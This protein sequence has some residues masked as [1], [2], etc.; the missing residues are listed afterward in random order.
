MTTSSTLERRPDSRTATDSHEH[1]NTWTCE[2]CRTETHAVRK[3]C[4]DCG[5]SRY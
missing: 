4:A 5:T 2:N 1:P 3:R